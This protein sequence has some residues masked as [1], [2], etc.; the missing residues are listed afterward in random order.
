MDLIFAHLEHLAL[1][2]ITSDPQSF[3]VFLHTSDLSQFYRN[4]KGQYH[5]T[6]LT[7][8]SRKL[9]VEPEYG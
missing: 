1:G 4:L 2:C 9:T 7:L 3:R 5:F 8:T 6:L